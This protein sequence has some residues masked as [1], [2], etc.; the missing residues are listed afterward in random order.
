[1]NIEWKFI[2]QEGYPVKEGRYLVTIEGVLEGEEP[3]LG[4]RC[5]VTARYYGSKDWGIR[6]GVFRVIAWSEL[7]PVYNLDIKN[8]GK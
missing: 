6:D 7:P 8:P 4:E 3:G 2:K 1:M 5:V